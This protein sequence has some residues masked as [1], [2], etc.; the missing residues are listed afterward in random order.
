MFH[1]ETALHHGYMLRAPKNSAKAPLQL[2]SPNQVFLR[3]RKKKWKEREKREM[4][5]MSLVSTI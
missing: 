5:R 3:S 4:G 1:A 2:H